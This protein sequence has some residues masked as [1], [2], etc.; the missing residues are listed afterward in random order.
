MEVTRA[1]SWLRRG[2]SSWPPERLNAPLVE[3][4]AGRIEDVFSSRAHTVFDFHQP[5]MLQ[6]GLAQSPG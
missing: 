2:R 4:L 3:E 1:S 6:N 5:T